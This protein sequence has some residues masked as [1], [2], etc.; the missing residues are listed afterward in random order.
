MI[1]YASGMVKLV[2]CDTG[3]TVCE[4]QAHSRQ[5]SALVCHPVR[6]IFASVSDDTF[7]NLWEV[8]GSKLESIDI[9][10]V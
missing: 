6:P 10:L 1:G 4:L 2:K 3:R 7:V 8:T 9:Q 5:V